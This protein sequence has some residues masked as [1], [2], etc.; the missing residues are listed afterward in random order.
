MNISQNTYSYW[1]NGKVK[2][3]CDSLKKLSLY[4]GVSVDEIMGIEKKE[5]LKNISALTAE[6]RKKVQQYIN[7][8]L[9]NSEYRRK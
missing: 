9:G 4:L 3:D 8:L 2:I 6:G 1:E 5:K 7:D